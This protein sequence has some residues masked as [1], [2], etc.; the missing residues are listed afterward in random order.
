MVAGLTERFRK[1]T[2][3]IKAAVDT[4]M[5]SVAR[6]HAALSSAVSEQ[7][8]Q[9]LALQGQ[10][11]TTDRKIELLH[12]AVESLT[13]QLSGNA[14]EAAKAQRSTRNMALLAAVSS[15]FAFGAV[16]ALLVLHR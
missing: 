5:A 6:T 3:D 8:D 16:V 4:E 10:I 13:R 2:R 11:S 15:A 9:L 14:S 12:K 1:D 7:R